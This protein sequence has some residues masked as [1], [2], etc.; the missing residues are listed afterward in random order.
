MNTILLFYFLVFGC[1]E[2]ILH[3]KLQVTPHKYLGCAEEKGTRLVKV[4]MPNTNIMATNRHLH[5][6]GM[7]ILWI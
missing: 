1:Q 5:L 4:G 7:W 3:L 6:S 2:N